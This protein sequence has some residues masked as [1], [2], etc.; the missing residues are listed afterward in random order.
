MTVSCDRWFDCFFRLPRKSLFFWSDFH[1]AIANSI[2]VSEDET[3][4][5]DVRFEVLPKDKKREASP[6][7]Y[8]DSD[9][10]KKKREASPNWYYDSDED[11]K[12]REAS[13]NWYYDSDSDKK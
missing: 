5:R 8:Y 7:W 1:Y 11:K 4:K 6:N 10:D 2:I 3:A 9:S 13:P 12:K